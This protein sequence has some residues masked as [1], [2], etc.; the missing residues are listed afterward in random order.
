MLWLLT[1]LSLSRRLLT[2][3]SLFALASITAIAQAPPSADTFVT[4]ATPNINYGSGI[5]LIVGPGIE[6]YIQFN[7]SGI[8]AG[9]TVS[10]ATLRLYVDAVGK[11]GGFDVYQLNSSWNENKLTYNTPSPSLGPSATGGSSTAI[12][13]NSLNQFV[14]IDISQQQRRHQLA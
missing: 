14:L 9:E 4:S 1:N 6:T 13:S 8:P 11:A 2:L 10:K 12:T 3:S 5:G 7:L